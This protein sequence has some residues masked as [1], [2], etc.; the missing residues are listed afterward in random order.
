MKKFLLS[1]TLFT[2]L[3]GI[4]LSANA[5]PCKLGIP[6]ITDVTIYTEGD[7]CFA[8][9]DLSFTMEKNSGNKFV[10]IDLW[11]TINYVR[12]VYS[13]VP[14]AAELNNSLGSILLNNSTDGIAVPT[15]SAYPYAPGVKVLR[16][17]TVTKTEVVA[18]KVFL[19]NITGIVIAVPKQTDNSCPVSLLTIKA[20]LYG[21]NSGSGGS[22]TQVQCVSTLSFSLGNPTITTAIR[23]CTQPRTLDFK[24]ETTSNSNITVKYSIFK[25]DGQIV[26]DEYIFDPTKDINVTIDGDVNK[27]I[28]K[29]DL[30]SNNPLIGD[31]VGFSG[32]TDYKDD[33][34]AKYWI[35]VYYTP[36]VGQG[37]EPL[38]YSVSRLTLTPC[39]SPAILPVSYASFTAT[40][41]NNN[42]VVL[43]WETAM[44][45]NNKGF[46]VQRN[47][48][49]VWK[50]I[51]FV[52]SQAEN[53]SSSSGFKYAFKDANN[54]KGISQYRILQVD[55]DGKGK[56]SSIRSV[57]GLETAARVVLFPNPSSNGSFSLLFEDAASIRDVV[58]RD[59][60][61]RVVKQ[62]KNI[63]G[64]TLTVDGLIDSF[65]TVQV[66][67]R[68]SGISSVEKVIIKKR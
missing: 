62:F 39:P 63:N 21:T 67:N 24:I 43:E 13:K 34:T 42:Q 54:N 61:G 30:G 36:E 37:Q 66:A 23:N 19:Y 68:T 46:H 18:G 11:Q 59:V 60:S 53:G 64:S 3:I 65:Y 22:S 20:D 15:Y 33:E 27:Q 40:R 47:V 51:G 12:P 49:G 57:Q 6:N 50:T 1:L 17:G 2:A 56:Y 4:T 8:K 45:E 48:D 35:V 41:A 10:G 32:N 31:D 9:F 29:T 38:T 26:N 44:E 14:T 52:F 58:V 55:I 16:T 5:Q 7:S 28:T 25:D